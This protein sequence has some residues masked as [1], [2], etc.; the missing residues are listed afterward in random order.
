MENL[1]NNMTDREILVY[2]ATKMD[3]LEEIQ[4]EQGKDI[5]RNAKAIE[6][7]K[8]WKAGVV[9][10]KKYQAWLAGIIATIIS[11]AIMIYKF[12]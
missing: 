7:L 5:S 8:E 2:V 12:R 10:I 3:S 6:K 4:K 11:L 9:G 1:F